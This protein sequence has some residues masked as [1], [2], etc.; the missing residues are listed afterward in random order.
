M[1][2]ASSLA[3]VRALVRLREAAALRSS[4]VDFAETALRWRPSALG[5]AAAHLGAPRPTVRF[6]LLPFKWP[7]NGVASRVGFTFSLAAAAVASSNSSCL[8]AFASKPANRSPASADAA[9]ATFESRS[10]LALAIASCSFRS[11]RNAAFSVARISA[12]VGCGGAAG[13]CC[14]EGV[15]EGAAAARRTMPV[16]N[17]AAPGCEWRGPTLRRTGTGDAVRPWAAFHGAVGVR[18]AACRPSPPPTTI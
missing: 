7:A 14:C 11:A 2:S 8:A 12:A 13:C 5:A 9:F 4:A 18:E 15:G 1:R 16:F 6:G 10:C 17:P 3:L